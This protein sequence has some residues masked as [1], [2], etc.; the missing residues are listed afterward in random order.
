M[1]STHL[2]EEVAALFEE[3]L[4]IDEGRLVLHGSADDLRERGA[5][6]TGPADKVD[7]FVADLTVLNDKQLGPTK[8]VTVYGTLDHDHRQE[9]RATGLEVGP[10]VLQDL[11]VHL[12]EPTRRPR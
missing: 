8:S 2:I 11:F 10:V 4:I 1:I 6:I 12:T 3:V 7:R 5:A 9:A